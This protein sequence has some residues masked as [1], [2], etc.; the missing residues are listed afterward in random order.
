[1]ISY[2]NFPI[3]YE[4]Y[5]KYKEERNVVKSLIVN[6]NDISGAQIILNSVITEHGN[7]V[8]GF[9]SVSGIGFTSQD[10][11]SLKHAQDHIIY[12]AS[13]DIQKNSTIDALNEEYDLG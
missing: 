5:Y 12:A 3:I 2:H 9:F 6:N 13:N 11:L 7:Y 8:S 4:Y 10:N 1:M